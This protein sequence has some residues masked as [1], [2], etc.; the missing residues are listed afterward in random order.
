MLDNNHF[1]IAKAVLYRKTQPHSLADDDHFHGWNIQRWRSDVLRD[2]QLTNAQKLAGCALAE[3]ASIN[4]RILWPTLD[5]IAAQLGQHGNSKRL[6]E[7][8]AAVESAGYL[9]RVRHGD[10]PKWNWIY[11]LKYP[12]MPRMDDEILRIDAR[13][14]STD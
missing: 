11:S 12:Y 10:G 4:A 3:I 9:Q 8:L 7:Y 14:G 5:Q 13:E 2:A 1:D 6:S